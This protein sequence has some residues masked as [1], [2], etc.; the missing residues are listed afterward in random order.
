MNDSLAERDF[1]SSR[2][3]FP[4]LAATGLFVL[5]PQ[6]LLLS[7]AESKQRL[8]AVFCRYNGSASHCKP[9][10]NEAALVGYGGADRRAERTFGR[11][12]QFPAENLRSEGE[13]P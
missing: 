2:R 12:W 8:A 5:K 9:R 4:S 10:Q 13:R 3:G 11:E 7:S 6:G 1:C